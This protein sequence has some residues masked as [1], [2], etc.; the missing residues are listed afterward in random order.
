MLRREL[1]DGGMRVLAALLFLLAALVPA[2]V[3]E[4]FFFIQASDSQFGYSARSLTDFRQETA[5]FEF[6]IATANRLRPAFVVVTGDL[7]NRASNPGQVAEYL[8][9]AAKLDKSIPLYNVPG[10]HDIGDVVAPD[11]LA[12]YR[13]SFGPDYYTFRHGG[14][15]FFVLNSCILSNPQRVPGELDKQNDWSRAELEKARRDGIRRM[16]VFQHHPWFLSSADEEDMY[17]NIA[18]ERRK[19]YLGLFRE[20][21]VSH[22]FAGHLHRNVVAKDAGIEMVVTGA[23]GQPRGKDHSGFRVVIVRPD[24]VEHHYYV[25]GVVPN[26]IEFTERPIRK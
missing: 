18:K 8:R 6:L 17:N 20:Y 22:V 5:N 2:Q 19:V 14:M 13:K 9:I 1:Y 12:N 25:M 21:G 23:I 4:P 3:A 7:V 11:H 16:I 24:S 26:R 15:A 10:N